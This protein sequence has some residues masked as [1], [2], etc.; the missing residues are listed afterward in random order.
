MPKYFR[1]FL[2]GD[3]PLNSLSESFLGF[4][5]SCI[6]DS[7]VQSS[8]FCKIKTVLPDPN[9]IRAMLRTLF[10]IIPSIFKVPTFVKTH[11]M[12]NPRMFKH[13]HTCTFIKHFKVRYS[14][15]WSLRELAF[16]PSPSPVPQLR[17]KFLRTVQLRNAI[18]FALIPL[19]QNLTYSIFLKDS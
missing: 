4:S 9:H 13:S 11:N 10:Y 7:C 5:R 18:R 6:S 14:I 1:I 2:S 8:S 3:Y 12:S 19:L 15:C 17:L 16:P